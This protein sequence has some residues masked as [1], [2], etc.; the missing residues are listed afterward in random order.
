MRL[1]CNSCRGAACSDCFGTGS[2]ELDESDQQALLSEFIKRTDT[3]DV[4]Y[5]A[6]SDHKQWLAGTQ[7]VVILCALWDEM[8]PETRSIAAAYYDAC[9]LKSATR[10]TWKGS[11]DNPL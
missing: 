3:H 7:V 8:T 2:T 1:V 11:R 4:T 9:V 6:S 10:Y 5:L